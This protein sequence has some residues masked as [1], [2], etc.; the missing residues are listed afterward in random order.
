MTGRTQLPAGGGPKALVEPFPQPRRRVEHAY[1][2]LD[3]ALYGSDEEKKAR[4]IHDCLPALGT[5]RRASI[6]SYGLR[7]GSGSIVLSPGSTTSTF[8]GRHR[9]DPRMLAIYI[10]TSSMRSPFSPT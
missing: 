9:D 3:V 2:E 6:P 1:R 10:R 7:F 5:H 4:A 8:L